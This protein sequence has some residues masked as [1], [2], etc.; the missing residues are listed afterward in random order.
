MGEVYEA[1]EDVLHRRVAVKTIRPG[2]ATDPALLERFDRERRVLARL[3]DTHIVPIFAT[4]KEGDLL[5]FAMPYIPG[6]ALNKVISTAQG[7]S[8]DAANS[9]LSSFEALV[10]EASSRTTSAAKRDS[11]PDRPAAATTDPAPAVGALANGKAMAGRTFRRNTCASVAAAMADVAEALHHAHADGIIHRDVK[12]SN[13]MVEP[14]G[15]PWLLDFGLARLKPLPTE[16]VPTKGDARLDGERQPPDHY[17][18][19][20]SVPIE[21]RS[22]TF[23]TV[24]TLPYMA[25]EQIWKGHPQA[26]VSDSNTDHDSKMDARTD[27]WGLGTTLYELLTLHRAFKNRDEILRNAPARLRSHVPNMPRDLESVCLKA[28]HKDREHR[29]QST[30]ALADDLKR[31]TRH[32]PVTAQGPLGAA[33]AALVE[34]KSGLGSGDRDCRIGRPSPG[35]KWSATG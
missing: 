26:Q 17:T 28:L 20:E 2:K 30:K 4:G 11:E 29:Y 23:G 12:P 34:A 1:E 14:S 22:L 32:E 8:H 21:S 18:N 35:C 9:P 3:H 19:G 24:G 6:V 27:V 33:G 7:H 31:W 5:Y 16:H 13:I 25:P 10:K 15:H